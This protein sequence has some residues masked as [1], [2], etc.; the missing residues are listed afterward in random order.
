MPRVRVRVLALAATLVV[1]GCGLF[2]HERT[3]APP[4]PIDIN[5]AS[6]RRIEEL[7]GITPSMARRIVDARP[8]DG[9]EDLVARGVL[10]E[11]ELARIADLVVVTPRAR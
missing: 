11:R 7:P 1:A 9:P 10:T 6:L 4:A 5:T 3:P 8:Y 2:R